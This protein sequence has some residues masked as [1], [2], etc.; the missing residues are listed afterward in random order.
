[1][2]SKKALR[3]ASRMTTN[4]TPATTRKWTRQNLL[5]EVNARDPVIYG[6]IVVFLGAI[7]PLASL[8]PARRAASV[9]PATVLRGDRGKEEPRLAP[10][11]AFFWLELRMF[12]PC[13]SVQLFPAP[14]STT[15]SDSRCTPAI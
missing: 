4:Q 3:T 13:C 6:V 1:M 7:A 10:V 5:F 14:A 9:H 15:R 12:G 2:R 8:V 11:A